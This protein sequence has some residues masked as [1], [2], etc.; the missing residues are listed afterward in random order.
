MAESLKEAA[1]GYA[2]QGWHVFPLRQGSKQ[3]ATA[4]G[5]KDATTDTAQV[6]AWW[7]ENPNYNIGVATGLSGLAVLDI[8]VGHSEGVDGWENLREWENKNAELPETLRA[9]TPSGGYHYYYRAP[10]GTELGPSVNSSLGIDLRAGGSYTVLPP[11]YSAE[12]GACWE[13]E[14]L[15]DGTGVAPWNAA[16]GAFH[17]Y[18]SPPKAKGQPL[19]LPD[20]VAEGN[21][22]DTIHRLACSLRAKGTN[23]EAVR[24]ACQ[25]V[26]KKMCRPPLPEEEV[27]KTVESAIS[28]IDRDRDAIEAIG[29]DGGDPGTAALL[30]LNGKGVP[31]ATAYN[32]DKV[33]STDPAYRGKF[34]FDEF[35]SKRMF[36]END[37]DEAAMARLDIDIGHR[38]G[39]SNGQALER[40]VVH[41]C[42]KNRRN[43]LAELLESLEWDGETRIPKLWRTLLGADDSEYNSAVALLTIHGAV[44]RAFEP[45][46]KFDYAPVLQSQRQGIGK[47]TTVRRLAMRP[48]WFTDSITTFDGKDSKE[49]L[50]GKWLVEISEMSAL[51]TTKEVESAKQ[52][53]SSQVDSY[54][55]AYGHAAI[56]HKRMCVFVGSTNTSNFLRDQTGNRRFLP[57]ECGKHEPIISPLEGTEEL[58]HYIEQVWAEGVAWYRS[59]DNPSGTL[60]LPG[61][62]QAQ[63]FAMQSAYTEE[64]PQVGMIVSHLDFVA[65]SSRNPKRVCVAE[66]CEQVFGL[67]KC[68]YVGK[69]SI[70]SRVTEILDRHAP[71]GWTKA[72]GPLSCGSY[73]KQR[74]WE[75]REGD[76]N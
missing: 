15:E 37:I 40:A 39:I 70:T 46:C 36:E 45:G 35:K 64:D 4:N 22:N 33:L 29:M 28:Y 25:D 72:S 60:Y 53:I 49:L 73:G 42:D 13:W 67:D 50:R 59:T 20:T 17:A 44:C 2:R 63:A 34:W 3:P 57:V 32:Y 7:A 11:S 51:K 68:Q 6:E 65:K 74:C 47:S 27:T 61:E 58:T 31:R 14:N 41:Q 10:E 71:K 66:V 54:R 43:P 75:Y 76:G 26:N 38:Y 62:V 48:E 52:F 1:L 18:V 69:R 16:V 19:E 8:D 9:T 5:F 55:P 56:D 23:A 21:R 24:I 12:R 30:D